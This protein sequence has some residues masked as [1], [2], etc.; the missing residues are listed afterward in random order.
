[1]KTLLLA[2][3]LALVSSACQRA[4]APV[5]EAVDRDT[6]IAT[7]VDLRMAALSSQSESVSP[8]RRRSILGEHGV[9][10]Q[11]LLSF[12]ETHGRDVEYMKEVWD[13][14]ETRMDSLK[15]PRGDVSGAPAP[16]G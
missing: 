5:S 15:L 4:S 6:F 10:A 14:V 9:T 16:G 7:Y 3:V 2:L 13:E 8:D 1:V 12:V 11:G